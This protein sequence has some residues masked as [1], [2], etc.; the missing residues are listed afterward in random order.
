MEFVKVNI[1]IPKSIHDKYVAMSA[2]LGVPKSSLMVLD[3][4]KSRDNDEVL[5]SM[6]SKN[7]DA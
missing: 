1:K 2:E 4:K 6:K 7:K 5:E 3:L